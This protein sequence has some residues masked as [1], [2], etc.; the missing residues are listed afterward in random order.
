MLKYL[1]IRELVLFPSIGWYL[2]CVT[3][4]F[5]LFICLFS[6]SSETIG[7]RELI[8][9]RIRWDHPGGSVGF[10]DKSSQMIGLKGLKFS[11]F[12]WGHPEMII[13]KIG[14]DWR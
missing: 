1:S 13:R 8:I 5:N 9:S 12:N 7:P 2:F 3:I 11:G 14:D 6:S 10:F 4:I